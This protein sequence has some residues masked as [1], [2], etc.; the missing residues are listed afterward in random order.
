MVQKNISSIANLARYK[1]TVIFNI[2]ITENEIS[3]DQKDLRKNLGFQN[4]F[5]YQNL[6]E[7]I[8]PYGFSE[9]QKHCYH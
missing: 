2:K 9:I 4:L 1:N 7:K 6:Q 8:V 3:L 5:L